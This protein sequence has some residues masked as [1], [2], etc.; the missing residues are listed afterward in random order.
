MV[1]EQIPQRDATSAPATRRSTAW[2]Q[3]PGRPGIL[4]R[5][6]LASIGYGASVAGDRPW[7]G[8]CNT[9]SEFNPCQAHF[10]RLVAAIKR[11][12]WAAGGFP[13]E[14]PTMSLHEQFFTRTTMLYRN[15]VSMET[16]ELISALPIDGVV[17]LGGCDKT[18]PAQLM[19]AASAD[20]P[21]LVVPAGPSLEGCFEGR[22]VRA[23]TDATRVWQARASGLMSQ[24]DV[25]R[26]EAALV[27]SC[28][29]CAVF[30][31]ATTMACLTEALGMTVFGAATHGAV[32]AARDRSAEATGTR[33]VDLIRRDVR[34][35]QLMT[36][37]SMS[38]ALRVLVAMGGSTNAVIHLRAV[39][40]RLG[41]DLPLES[42]DAAG[43]DTP[44]LC[45]VAPN[46]PNGVGDFD[47]EGGVPALMRE[48]SPL[49]DVDVLRPSGRRLTEE[50][51]TVPRTSGEVIARLERP[52][53]PEGGIAVVRGNLAPDGAVLKTS[54]ASPGLFQHEG[55]AVVFDSRE[56]YLRA[57]GSG[58]TDIGADDVL[59][60]RN[61]GPIGGPG[62]PEVGQ[63]MLLPPALARAGITDMVRITDGRM[64]GTAFGTVVVHV[65]PEAAAGGALG[66]ARTGDPIRL[67][68]QARELSLAVTAEE[69]A[70]RA[71]TDKPRAVP[72]RPGYESMYVAHVESADRGC[73]F[74]F[75]SGRR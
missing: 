19:A 35:S 52:L 16:E 34:P 42:F 5:A 29:T 65:A 17:L 20:L 7:V 32:S 62:M 43:R 64:S 57:I 21:A 72:P 23:G 26:F 61:Q 49:L 39:A 75:L 11:G 70:S 13:M 31:T 30:G 9:W 68:V 44:L 67:D 33:I 54:A 27:P 24:E 8:I 58:G 14:F 63:D 55:C 41:I 51:A 60:L 2:L 25:A 10:P 59:I 3:T 69:L 46:G 36:A 28:G 6:M 1:R 71:R 22:T 56:D 66:L 50:L 48:L 38:N 45:S 53:R 4:R 73:D 12:V 40:G 74:D 18:I 47:R 37:A 15:L